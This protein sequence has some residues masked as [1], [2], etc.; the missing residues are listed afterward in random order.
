MYRPR[1]GAAVAA[2]A[3]VLAL[4]WVSFSL[5]RAPVPLKRFADNRVGLSFS[6]PATW[7]ANTAT[8][9]AGGPVS[10]TNFPPAGYL[11]GGILPPGGA[12]ITVRMLPPHADADTTLQK[13][14]RGAVAPTFSTP[15]IGGHVVQRVRYS[16]TVGP[17][18]SYDA[19]A[20]CLQKAGKQFLIMLYYRGDRG[21]GEQAGAALAEVVSSVSV[22]GK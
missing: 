11:H 7:H 8:L 22:G 14:T 21:V 9:A 19:T 16:F 13:M 20:L 17:V 12:S 10:I 18:V 2:F 1:T 4:T 6:Y 15:S 3:T 5:A